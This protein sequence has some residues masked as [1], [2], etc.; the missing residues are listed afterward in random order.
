MKI[1]TKGTAVL[2]PARINAWMP[3]QRT[4]LSCLFNAGINRIK[5]QNDERMTATKALMA[6][7]SKPYRQ[8]K[9]PEG[10]RDLNT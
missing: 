5:C 9:Y 8:E 4:K 2:N 3:C 7:G 1:D 10:H 6:F